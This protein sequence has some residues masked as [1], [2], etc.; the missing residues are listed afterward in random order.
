MHEPV[1][2]ALA[3]GLIVGGAGGFFDTSVMT[4]S[5]EC[6]LRSQLSRTREEVLML[7]TAR[8][9]DFAA[10]TTKVAELEAVPAW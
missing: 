9:A 10:L 7:R 4:Q 1:A 8:D 5:E 6:N 3:G 2:A